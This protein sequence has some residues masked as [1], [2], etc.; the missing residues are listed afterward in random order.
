MKEMISE[1]K[2]ERERDKEAPWH[3]PFSSFLS[4]ECLPW[5]NVVRDQLAREPGECRVQKQVPAI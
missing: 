1:A 2:R 3:L 5:A 4:C